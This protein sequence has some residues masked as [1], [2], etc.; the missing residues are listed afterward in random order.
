MKDWPTRSPT[1][2]PVEEIKAGQTIL[3][4]L[5]LRHFGPTLI[6]CPTCGRTQVHLIDLA[7]EVEQAISHLTVPI[8]VAVMGCVVNGPGEAREAD[9]GI[10]GGQGK[11]I[12][13]SHGQ[14]LRTVPEDQLVSS[15]VEEIEKTI[16]KES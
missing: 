3:S 7:Q 10:A 4:S 9:F 11:G 12:V 16:A 15:L 2:D 5:G 6:S 14:V 1:G 13:F 8:K